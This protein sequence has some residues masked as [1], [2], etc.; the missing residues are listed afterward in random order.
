[1]K[2]FIPFTDDQIYALRETDSLVP[3]RP[4]LP[5]AS[6]FSA[7]PQADQEPVNPGATEARHRDAGST[8]QLCP[9]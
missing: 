5:L 1:M 7:A 6:Q 2:A 8:L 3:Y 4:G 9:R